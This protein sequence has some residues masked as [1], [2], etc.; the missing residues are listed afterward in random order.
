MGHYNAQWSNLEFHKDITS[1]VGRE[2]APEH[3][4]WRMANNSPDCQEFMV[5]RI[6]SIVTIF[7]SDLMDE[8]TLI[9]VF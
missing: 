8:F 7:M 2:E 1:T 5:W 9:E 3:F 4:F 6:F